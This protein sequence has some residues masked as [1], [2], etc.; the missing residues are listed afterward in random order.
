VPG[1]AQRGNEDIKD[2]KGK[3]YH[4]SLPRVNNDLPAH[5]GW[6]C[7]MVVTLIM[8]VIA[9]DDLDMVMVVMHTFVDGDVDM[10]L[11]T[12]HIPFLHCLNPLPFVVVYH[13]L[14]TSTFLPVD[15]DIH[16][17]IT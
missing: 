12:I 5:P 7:L 14:S 17:H 3:S 6:G 9:C 1:G 4:L 15:V 2:Q 10:H 16:P 11:S 8:V 13:P